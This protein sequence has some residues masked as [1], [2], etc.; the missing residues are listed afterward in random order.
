MQIDQR[1]GRMTADVLDAGARPR[2]TTGNRELQGI[3]IAKWP[4][5]LAGLDLPPIEGVEREWSSPFL[6]S[7]AQQV[8]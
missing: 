5:R 4:Y 8:G 2:A 6:F 1:T 7:G 3:V